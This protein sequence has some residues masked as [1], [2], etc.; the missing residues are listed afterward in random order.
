MNFVNLVL[1]S[2]INISQHPAQ[3]FKCPQSG[4]DGDRKANTSPS[5]TR[6]LLR[7][8][9]PPNRF[10]FGLEQLDGWRR[11]NCSA[12]EN[13]PSPGESAALT[14]RPPRPASHPVRAPHSSSRS[15]ISRRSSL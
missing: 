3:V 1:K 14:W 10:T 5:T 2:E 15:S 6:N 11:K 12:R 7:W 8:Y 4:V 9:S 13:P